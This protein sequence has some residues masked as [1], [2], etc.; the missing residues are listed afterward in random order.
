MRIT[1]SILALALGLAASGRVA[2]EP[3]ERRGF[4]LEFG[5]GFGAFHEI[6]SS[7]PNDSHLGQSNFSFSLGGF[8]R[9]DTALLFHMQGVASMF[10]DG[11][12]VDM[13][14]FGG[15]H[16]QHWLKDRLFVGGGAGMAIYSYG[17]A[18]LPYQ[19]KELHGLGVG[20]RSGYSLASSRTHSLHLALEVSAGF[21][22]ELTTITETLVF[23]WQWMPSNRRVPAP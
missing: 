10:E 19:D 5:L 1:I 11:F 18:L 16:V 21:F 20:L 14:G 3:L 7:Y 9:P 2:A 13:A 23:E 22:S 8:L 12:T 6:P 17:D 4:T 15:V